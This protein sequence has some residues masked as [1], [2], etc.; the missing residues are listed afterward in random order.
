MKL[1]IIYP[2]QKFFAHISNVDITKISN[3]EFNKIQSI[4]E[5]YGVTVIKDQPLNDEQQIKFSKKFGKLETPLKKDI[6]KGIAPEITRISNVGLNNK[7]LEIKHEKVIY[8]RGNNHWHSDSS[9]K[10]IP[11]KFS[12]LSARE[13]PKEGGGTEFIDASHALETWHL[14]NNKYNLK[15]I[16]ECICKHSLVYSRMINTGDI[17]DKNFK[18]EMPFVKQRLIRTHPFTKRN[19]F[20]AGSHCSHIIGWNI[21]ESR[22]LIKNIN[23]WII[24]AGEIASHKWSNNEIVIWDNRRVQHRGTGFNE[25][26]YR[27]I[28]HRTTVAGDIESYK[29][30]VILN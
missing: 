4:I 9:F 26:K 12:I 8:D 22:E 14:N 5:T 1:E 24:N 6:L 19:A 11:A 13:I 25:A 21:E 16:K 2:N 17:F 27:R 29:E 20:F 15:N 23:K 10:H 3:K 7:K 28:M 18:A 30:K